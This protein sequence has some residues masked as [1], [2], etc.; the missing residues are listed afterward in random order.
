MIL[1]P[2]LVCLIVKIIQLISGAK[3][4]SVLMIICDIAV[5]GFVA[6]TI[7]EGGFNVV[8]SGIALVPSAVAL[9]SNIGGLKN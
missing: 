4:F 7:I 3:L 5:I 6:Y 9:I 8:Y 2:Y 1:V